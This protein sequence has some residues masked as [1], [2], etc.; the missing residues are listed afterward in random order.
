[1]SPR[2]Q[3]YQCNSCPVS[4][5][6]QSI[7]G[8]SVPQA[9]EARTMIA[10]ITSLGGYEKYQV[11]LEEVAEH[12]QKLANHVVSAGLMPLSRVPSAFAEGPH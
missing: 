8:L 6:E 11:K 7:K 9:E 3:T 4:R 10:A 5:V 12:G 2:T 1:M